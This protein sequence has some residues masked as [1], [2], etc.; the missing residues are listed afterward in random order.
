[1]ALATTTTRTPTVMRCPVC[2]GL[3][4]LCRPRFFA[5]QLLT[6]ED[7]NRLER[8]IVEKNKLHNRYLHG[9]GVVC[10]LEVSCHPCQGYVSVKSGYALSPCGDDMVVCQDEA[11]N[12]CELIKK[13]R[14]DAQRRWDCDPEWPRPAPDC[15]DQDEPWI[16]YLCYTEQ[17]SRGVTALR[18]ASGAS[19][20]SRCSCG[21]SSSCGCG[22]HAK[23][24]GMRKNRC[25]TKQAKTPAQ[26]EPTLTCEGYTFQIQKAR[27]LPPRAD[28]RPPGA[29]VSNISECLKELASIQEAVNDLINT[30][31]NG[32]NNIKAA[33]LEY[34]EHQPVHNCALEQEIRPFTLTV[35]GGIGGAQ[36]FFRALLRE[37]LRECI[38][39]ALLPPCPEPVEDDCVP[40]ATI[41]VNC[42]DGCRVVRVCNWEQR[43][44]VVT[45]PT[46]EY[47]FEVLLRQSGLTELLTRFC[48]AP[49]QREGA[50]FVGETDLV[51][52]LLTDAAQN[53]EQVVTKSIYQKLGEM[54]KG[55]LAKF[56]G[57]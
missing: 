28:A 11:V 15:G 22:C 25:H 40:I 43:R 3:E 17:P 37:L 46:I 48:C 38:C 19:C 47:W 16:L 45:F 24:N 41:T 53:Q 29:L 4:C 36:V 21:G 34:L 20:C 57:Q 52:S 23:T 54:L 35:E 18:G 39:S 14:E 1:M 32:V 51:E 42:K 50:A 33:L 9:W 26:C 10:G 49:L 8:Y 6:E 31:A 30:G 44:I 56:T 12:V 27:P 5:G 7:L 55:L 2:G 13:C